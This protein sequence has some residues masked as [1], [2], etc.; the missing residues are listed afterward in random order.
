MGYRRKKFSYEQQEVQE[1][2]NQIEGK[3]IFAAAYCRLSV[4]NEDATSIENQKRIIKAYMDKH[5]EIKLVGTYADNG[6]TGT[7]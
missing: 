5:P 3:Y 7:N 1:N 4:E 6:V 2:L